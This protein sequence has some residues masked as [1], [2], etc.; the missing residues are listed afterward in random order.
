MGGGE[1]HPIDP[2]TRSYSSLRCQTGYKWTSWEREGRGG[3][4]GGRRE[5]GDRPRMAQTH[6]RTDLSACAREREHRP[7]SFIPSESLIKGECFPFPQPLPFSRR[8]YIYIRIYSI[9][10]QIPFERRLGAPLS[11]SLSL[12]CNVYH[13]RLSSSSLHFSMCVLFAKTTPP[14]SPRCANVFRT[15]N[16][17]TLMAMGNGWWIFSG[18]DEL[19]SAEDHS[20]HD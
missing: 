16:D 15:A 4:N 13:P 17:L 7:L 11:L 20:R 1:T 19:D 6:R 3:C 14:S 10:M 9:D 5:G 8:I 12:A 18:H 2:S